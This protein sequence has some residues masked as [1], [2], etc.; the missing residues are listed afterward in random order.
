MDFH[1]LPQDAFVLK[2]ERKRTWWAVYLL[3]RLFFQFAEAPDRTFLVNSAQPGDKLPVEDELWVQQVGND[4]WNPN[5][6]SLSEAV[7]S[8]SGYFS[9]QI[10]A[11]LLLEQVIC[12][13]KIH[14]ISREGMLDHDLWRLDL[15][16]Q[17]TTLDLLSIAGK[18]WEKTYRA[19]V[20]LLLWVSLK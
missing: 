19:I 18:D 7:E 3:D 6:M 10:Q 17:Q 14:A 8:T 4:T 5:V 12:F 1:L 16:I 9:H 15:L 13:N 2:E 20:I 11:T